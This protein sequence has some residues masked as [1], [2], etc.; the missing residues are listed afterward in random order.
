MPSGI[1]QE[2]K[3]RPYDVKKPHHSGMDLTYLWPSG[4]WDPFIGVVISNH[5]FFT[6]AISLVSARDRKCM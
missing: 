3:K 4:A 2:K 6:G 1:F 5:L